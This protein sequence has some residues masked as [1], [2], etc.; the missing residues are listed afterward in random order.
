MLPLA[1][2]AIL[3][4]IGEAVSR[5]PETLTAA[6]PEVRWRSMRGMRNL[7]AHEYE[8][9]DSTIMWNTLARGIAR[10]RSSRTGDRGWRVG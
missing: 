8:V 10:R 6:C 4:K 7:V 5:L 2:E 1:A 3:L 9:V